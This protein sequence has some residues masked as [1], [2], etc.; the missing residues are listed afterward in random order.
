MSVSPHEPSTSL[1]IVAS[2]ESPMISD[3]EMIAEA[4]IRPIIKSAACLLRRKIFSLAKRHTTSL[5]GT[6]SGCSKTW[7]NKPKQIAPTHN[8]RPLIWQ[9]PNS[10]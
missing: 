7:L 4:I 9:N 8:V 5:C 3:E 2:N 1:T 6:N 10:Q